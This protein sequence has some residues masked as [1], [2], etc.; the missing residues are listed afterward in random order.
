MS[1]VT[2]LYRPGPNARR[3]TSRL[4]QRK[5]PT[6]EADGVSLIRWENYYAVYL[7]G[8]DA[9]FANWRG[10]SVLP[11]RGSGR[12]VCHS[13]LSSPVLPDAAL[14]KSYSIWLRGGGVEI[15]QP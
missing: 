7:A 6:P 2:N 4:N 12:G 9:I 1:G 11:L 3:A 5:P 8:R 15:R 14:P 10:T 13:A